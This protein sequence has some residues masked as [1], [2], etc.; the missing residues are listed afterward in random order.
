MVG[1]LFLWGRR[2]GRLKCAM[3]IPVFSDSCLQG[4]LAAPE[5]N[6]RW[7]VK[8]T[9]RLPLWR[10]RRHVRTDGSHIIKDAFLPPFDP[11]LNGWA[12]C[13]K[14]EWIVTFDSEAWAES[15]IRKMFILSQN[16][17]TV[18]SSPCGC[19]GFD[20][21]CVFVYVLCWYRGIVAVYNWAKM[22][23]HQLHFWGH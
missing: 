16:K 11:W 12:Q 10:S 9:S 2:S 4:S 14:A 13:R 17:A 6:P 3:K 8:L 1:N 18:F 7:D 15:A 23:L 5:L 21:F 22:H 20:L 19:A